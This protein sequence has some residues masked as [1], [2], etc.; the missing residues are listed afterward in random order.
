MRR[1]P[2]LGKNDLPHMLP[3]SL[4]VCNVAQVVQNTLSL[5]DLYLAEPTLI[6]KSSII[7]DVK[8]WD[9]ET[10]MKEMEKAVRKIE[11]DGLLWGACKF[12]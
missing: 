7:L 10:D 12:P 5:I 11:T 9:D 2:R 6:A 1:L 8:P 4:K 3:K